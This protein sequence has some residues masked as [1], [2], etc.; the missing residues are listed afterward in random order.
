MEGAILTIETLQDGQ[1][2]PTKTSLARDR[3]HSLCKKGAGVLTTKFAIRHLV[4]MWTV[5][6][7]RVEQTTLGKGQ[8]EGNIN[9]INDK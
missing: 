2:S 4:W 9:V 7:L 1:V 8:R 6:Q 5:P 3:C